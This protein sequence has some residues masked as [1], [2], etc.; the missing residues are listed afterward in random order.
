MFRIGPSTL[1]KDY[2]IKNNTT[3]KPLIPNKLGHARKDYLISQA[4]RN[5]GREIMG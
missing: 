5:D 3:T 2:L 4:K 1:C